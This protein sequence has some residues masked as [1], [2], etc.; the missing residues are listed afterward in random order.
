MS[1]PPAPFIVGMGRSGTTLL[2]MMLDAHPL[3]AIP[4]ETHFAPAVMAFER[5]GVEAAVAAVFGNGLWEDYGLSAEEFARRARGG[6][7]AG[8]GEVLRAFY[9]LYAESRGKPRW[10][11]KSPYYVTVMTHLQELLPEARFIHVVRDGRDVAVSTVPLWFGADDVAGVAREWSEKL[12]A[13]RR[14][15][16]ELHSYMEVRYED[17]VREPAAVLKRVCEFLELDWTPLLLEYHR[18]AEGRLAAELGAVRQNGRVLSAAERRGIHPLL[19]EPPRPDRIG[20]WRREMSAADR[21]LFDAVAAE[22]LAAYGY[23]R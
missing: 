17:L 9:E 12:T 6:E 7:P 1:R 5:D 22:T 18:E 21:E 13:A 8:A 20:R 10:G 11:D 15:A 16:P 3:L 4:A 23:E 14:Q 2:R 19:A